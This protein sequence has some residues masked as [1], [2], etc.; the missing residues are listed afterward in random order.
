LIL[1][2]ATSSAL[3]NFFTMPSLKKDFRVLVIAFLT[4]FKGSPHYVLFGLNICVGADRDSF[5]D[6]AGPDFQAL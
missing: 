2:A 3:A 1:Y 4:K 6:T 5:K